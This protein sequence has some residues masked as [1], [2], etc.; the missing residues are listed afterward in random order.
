MDHSKPTLG[1]QAKLNTGLEQYRQRR[2]NDYAA[3]SVLMLLWEDDDL[4][5][6]EEVK[7]LSAIFR[8]TFHYTVRQFLIPTERP[9]SSLCRVVSDFIYEFGSS[10]NLVLVYYGGHGDPDLNG[11]REAVWAA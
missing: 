3:V 2:R 4:G 6:I 11:D 5:C 7:Q 8:E 1:L 10:G 9:Q